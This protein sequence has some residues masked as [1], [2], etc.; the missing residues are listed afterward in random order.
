MARQL[1]IQV[2]NLERDT[3]RMRM[4]ADA[5]SDIGL[6]FER[7]S[8][9]IGADALNE[10]Q[11]STRQILGRDL[12]PGEVG[13]YLSHLKAIDRFLAT[14]AQYGLVLEDDAASISDTAD[15]LAALIE[16]LPRLPI[17]D[18]VNIGRSVKSEHTPVGS[19]YCSPDVGLCHAHYPPVTTTALLWSRGGARAF[20]LL[21]SQP[22]LPI[23]L[24]I[25]SWGAETDRILALMRPIFVVREGESTI[26]GSGR[27]SGGHGLYS[28]LARLRRIGWNKWRARYNRIR[29]RAV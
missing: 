15:R 18:V 26:K 13:C 22:V 6:S 17:W 16:V 5:L 21:H 20:R 14:D 11:T 28:I 10:R 2:V 1:F 29:R 19:E 3:E 8:A 9:V 23:D 25:Q 4:T 7:L 27:R 24:A 12:Y